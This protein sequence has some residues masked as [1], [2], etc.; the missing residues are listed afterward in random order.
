MTNLDDQKNYVVNCI[1]VYSCGKIIEYRVKHKYL[2]D[3]R[4]EII[5]YEKT[6][7]GIEDRYSRNAKF[8]NPIFIGE[9]KDYIRKIRKEK[10]KN[11]NE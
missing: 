4:C 5:C 11:L 9:K 6:C 1:D 3:R 10:L 2:A 7:M 8:C